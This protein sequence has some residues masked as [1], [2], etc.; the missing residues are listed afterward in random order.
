MLGIAFL[1]LFIV[2]ILSQGEPPMA[3]DSADD[4]REFFVDNRDSY[5]VSD[6]LIGIALVFLFLP[7]AICLHSLLIRAEGA[8][9]IIS[10]LF[11][12][13]VVLT[14]AVGF[15]GSL[16]WGTLAMGAGDEAMDDS[17]IKTLMYM[18]QYGSTGIHFGFAITALAGAIVMLTTSAPA[19]WLGYVGLAAFVLNLIGA[20]WVIDGDEEGLISLLGLVGLL[21]FAIWTLCT[22]IV[23]LRLRQPDSE[24]TIT[25]PEAAAT[26]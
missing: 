11:L 7:F 13:G 2:A 23:M 4:I 3:S 1:I 20:A 5:L 15:A 10:N 26:A 19:R 8:P 25:A 12:G 17:T 6:F 14:L 22:S 16:G 18:E 21:G 9:G 24:S